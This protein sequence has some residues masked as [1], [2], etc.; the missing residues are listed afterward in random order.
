MP[1]TMPKNPRSL[2]ILSITRTNCDSQTLKLMRLQNATKSYIYVDPTKSTYTGQTACCSSG[3]KKIDVGIQLG[4]GGLCDLAQ[5]LLNEDEVKSA[6]PH[7][8]S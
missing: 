6:E 2:V 4:N 1:Q 5:V 8:T 3:R 7:K